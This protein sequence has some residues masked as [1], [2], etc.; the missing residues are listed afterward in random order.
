[1][2]RSVA[3]TSS[4][5]LASKT[6]VWRSKFIVA[7]I[8]MGF[9]VLAGR[10]AWVQVFANDFF[11]RQGE[12]RFARTLELPANRGRILDR[13]GLL[14]ASSVPAPSIWAIPE[15]VERDHAKLARLAK[16][17]EMPLAELEKKLEDEDKT[18][19]WLKRQVDD[20]VAQQITALDIKG[21]YQRKEYKRQYPE[22]EAA[23]HVVGFTNV[24]DRGQEGVELTFE[25]D[26]AGRAGMRR[27]I[28]DRLGR[29]VE[30]VG[31]Q[32]Q[33]VP[34]RDLQLSIDSK[35]QFF[36][37]Q[38]LR[39]AV[40][41]HKARAGSV[42]VL[43]AVTGELL[44][45]ANYPSYVPGRRQNL[46][47]EQLRNR[48]MTDVFEPGSTMKPFTIG[49]ALESGLVTPHTPIQTA[50]GFV[51][52]GGRKI[53]D[54][55]PHG[56]LSVQQVIQKS[57][58]VGT[59]KLALQMQPREMW[60]MFTQAG[61]G[62]KPQIAFPGAVTGRLRPY[63]SWKPVE[64]A[65][66]SYGY[67]LSASLFQ[68]ARSYTIFAHD[69]QI[70]PATM[71]KADGPATGTR[72]FS[73]K[74]VAEIRTM[75]QM[76]AGPG[77]TGPKA[78]TLGYSVGGKSGTAYKQVG[79]GYVT[80]KY[81]SWFVGIAPIEK[82][83]IIVAVMLDEPSNGKYYGG[84]VAAPVFSA[85]VQQTLRMLGVQPDMNVKPQIVVQAVEESF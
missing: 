6:P 38:K 48:A 75:L 36:A 19:V 55:H 64:Q 85:T 66:M 4:P 51:V 1:M 12:V 40:L 22:G 69:G 31:E 17:L 76:A 43:D 83:R 65:T 56:V 68:V 25:K 78:Q 52:M 81:R 11:Q 80:N 15:D 18:F 63:K 82:P 44:A 58:N 74:T 3:Y 23:A 60:E 73:P 28:K 14:L 67:G 47:G 39:D 16:L 70:I 20:A 2:T 46:S 29:V 54:S 59:L 27:V 5:L 84:E 62:Q 50:P 8:A 13:N 33:P 37:Y 71:L 72:V 10:A 7:A 32:V 9:V 61:F 57:S 34:G 35:V 45:L 24:E 21:I 42:V 77:G 53:S 79:K 41:E 26:L 49:L 30:D